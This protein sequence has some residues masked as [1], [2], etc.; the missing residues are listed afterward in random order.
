MKKIFSILLTV[1]FFSSLSAQTVVDIIVNSPDHNTLE[2]AVIAAEL[3]DDL[4]GDGPFTVFAPTDAAFAAIDPAVLDELLQDPTGDLANILLFHVVFGVADGTNIVDGLTIGSLLNQNLSF[5]ISGGELFV[6]GAK[7]SVTD[8][9]AENGV[10]HVLDAVMLPEAMA[11]ELPETIMDV[12][13]TSPVHTQLNNLIIAAGLDDELSSEGPFTL[14]A[15]T[16]NAIAALPQDVVDDLLADPTGALADILLLHTVSGVATTSNVMDGTVIG[17]L[18]L[19]NL[20]FTINANGV[21]I[22]DVNISVLDIRTQNGVVH[23]IDAVLL[24]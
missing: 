18:S 10:V 8:L 1:A 20:A 9:R 16:D 11:P 5:S 19:G 2:T 4:S 13:S 21:F 17:S 3:A 14:F 24:P 23:V 15:P 12:V 22:N 6:N 7:I